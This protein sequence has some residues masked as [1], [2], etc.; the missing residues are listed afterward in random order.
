MSFLRCRIQYMAGLWLAVVSFG[1]GQSDAE[2]GHREN[3]WRSLDGGR[4]WV[5]VSGRFA[6]G[7][8]TVGLRDWSIVAGYV[9]GNRIG[10][11]E[12]S[13]LVAVDKRRSS[14]GVTGGELAGVVHLTNYPWSSG[15]VDGRYVCCLARAVGRFQYRTVEG[16]SVV[17]LSYDHG[18]L[19]S[20]EVR[21][22]LDGLRSSNFVERA[23]GAAAR[24]RSNQAARVQ[25]QAK[26]T[27]VS[28]VPPKIPGKIPHQK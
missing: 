21:A 17:V 12:G 25:A 24:A 10:S 16:G 7:P 5:D 4:S 1:Y 15:L 13:L 20:A 18:I 2:V 23:Q 27:N 3:P 9:F 19:P 28:I 8:V 26:G 6:G 11:R 14:Y 22:G